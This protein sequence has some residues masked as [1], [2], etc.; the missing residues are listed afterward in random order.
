MR[1]RTVKG[2]RP[3]NKKK[4]SNVQF[5]WGSL[6]VVVWCFEQYWHCQQGA[7]FSVLVWAKGL[8]LILGATIIYHLGSARQ[9]SWLGL[10]PLTWLA[11]SRSQWDICFDAQNVSWYW[12]VLFLAAMA[13]VFRVH[14]GKKMLLGLVP[15]WA[16]LA[17]LWKPSA[18][19]GLSFATAERGRFKNDRWIR[20]GGMVLALL[21]AVCT[22]GSKGILANGL[23][24]Y[25]IL[26]TKGYIGFFLLAWLGLVAFPPKGTVRHGVWPFLWLTVGYYLW[27]DPSHPWPLEDVMYQWVLIFLAGFGFESFKRDVM[28]PSW[29]AVL[30]WVAMGIGLAI[31]IL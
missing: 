4:S 12:M 13:L 6:A 16:G 20:W 23:G 3:K 30:V 10:F 22:L 1:T 24:L 21:L 14:D 5:L 15:L 17:L 29:H 31:G 25:D 18:L 2:P 26:A 28:D 27:T 8:T 19:L 7:S 11:L 9:F